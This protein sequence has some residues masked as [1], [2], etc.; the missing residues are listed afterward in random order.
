MS[1]SAKLKIAFFGSDEFSLAL[2][3]S[4]FA[5]ERFEIICIFTKMPRVAGRGL[6]LKKTAVH[7][8]VLRN[9]IEVFTPKNLK[10]IRLPDGI[11]LGIVVSY[12]LLIPKHF[13]DATKFGFVNV[14]PSLL[15][16]WRGPSPMIFPL[17][18]GETE[19]GVSIML[20]DEG[21]DSG[22]VLKQEQIMITENDNSISLVQK[23]TNLSIN[24][25]IPTIFD[26]LSDKIKPVKQD[27]SQ[28]TFCRKVT[29]DFLKIDFT[30]SG[31]EIIGQIRAFSP[32]PGAFFMFKNKRIKIL[33]TTFEKKSNLEQKCGQIVDKDFSISCIDG[34]ILPEILQLDGKKAL[35]KKDF[36]NGFRFQVGDCID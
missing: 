30:K 22:D 10:N 32:K 12:G 11:D 35:P 17:L 15:P 27:H 36:I 21:M 18:K 13:L 29:S 33:Q 2:L 16:K 31:I 34:L 26:W 7:E 4:V 14:H 3:Q 8:F 19:T 1:S 6:Q 24:L 28:A 5:D 25:L 23:L 9:N 20:L